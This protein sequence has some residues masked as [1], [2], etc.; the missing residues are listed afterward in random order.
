MS[1]RTEQIG[2][3]RKPAGTRDF[4]ISVAP[5]MVSPPCVTRYEFKA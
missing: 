3:A 5:K 2:I 1:S 4:M